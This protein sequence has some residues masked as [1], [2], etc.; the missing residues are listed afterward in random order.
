MALAEDE[1]VVETLSPHRAQETLAHRI[2]QRCPNGRLQHAHVG[3]GGDVVEAAAEFSISVSDDESRSLAKWRGISELLGS[4]LFGRIASDSDMHDTLGVHIDDE[5]SE[6]GSKPDVVDLEKIAGPHSVIAEKRKPRLAT[7]RRRSTTSAHVFLHCSFR[8]PDTELEEFTAYSL[9]A[10]QAIVTS[11]A[12]NEL[13][14]A[15]I[16]TRLGLASRSR[17]PT[18]EEAEAFPMPAQNRVRLDQQHRVSP[19]RKHAGQHDEQTALQPSEVGPFDGPGRYD[20]LL[21]EQGVLGDE[22]GV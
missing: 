8:D 14:D 5:E 12:S 18:P 21:A 11:H 15:G 13:D 9:R 17:A 6:D 10:P 7:P 22:F 1:H 19:M 4:P 20:E 2:H 3:T 16:D